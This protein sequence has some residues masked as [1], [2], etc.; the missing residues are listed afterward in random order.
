MGMRMK[1]YILRSQ[2]CCAK[3]VTYL[4]L[5]YVLCSKYTPL[6]LAIEE[7]SEKIIFGLFL[8]Y[9]WLIFFVDKEGDVEGD[10]GEEEDEDDVEEEEGVDV[11]G[12]HPNLSARGQEDDE[13]EDDDEDDDDFLE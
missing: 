13:E 5:L 1:F 9:F 12:T 2:F 3:F 10:E 7:K 6:N 11:Q 4:T 8:A